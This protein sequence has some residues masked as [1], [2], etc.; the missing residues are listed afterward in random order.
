MQLT[1]LGFEDVDWI[2]HV[3]EE[4]QQLIWEEMH[5]ETFSQK[6]KFHFII[7]NFLVVC[8]VWEGPC[9]DKI[10]NGIVMVRLR[11]TR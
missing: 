1:E 6:K 3:K 7:V 11:G 5:I 4:V 10:I 2:E 9:N 8:C